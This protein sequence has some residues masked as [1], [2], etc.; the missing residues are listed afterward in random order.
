MWVFVDL[1]TRIGEHGEATVYTLG[2]TT[3]FQIFFSK[4]SEVS[5]CY[6]D[7]SHRE[8]YSH[9]IC[10]IK[11]CHSLFEEFKLAFLQETERYIRKFFRLQFF[12]KLQ[13]QSTNSSSKN[14]LLKRFK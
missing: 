8:R 9:E 3:F 6:F 13:R 2:N 14:D 5:K 7:N 1:H 10:L 11:V 12:E 4:R